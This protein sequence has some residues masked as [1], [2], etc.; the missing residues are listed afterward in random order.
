MAGAR[1]FKL[2]L[3]S[4]SAIGE[5]YAAE[6]ASSSPVRCATTASSR[7]A[8]CSE[9]GLTLRSSGPPP[10]WR[11]A[12]EAVLSV[13]I[14]L[15]GQAPTRRGPLSSNVRPHNMR[16]ISHH[17]ALVLLALS[18]TVALG[19][20]LNQVRVQRAASPT[21]RGHVLP[22]TAQ[23]LRVQEL[24]AAAKLREPLRLQLSSIERHPFQ[25]PQRQPSLRTLSHHR[26]LQPS[27]GFSCDGRQYCS[28]MHSCAEAK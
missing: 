28:Q 21:N 25:L 13:I 26:Q 18:S 8:S 24:N 4:F 16:R 5:A 3:S 12:R 6:A 7:V 27:T 20:P 9:R 1:S 14:R 22:I 11:L 17:V 15:A 10:A 19:V 2:Q 23:R